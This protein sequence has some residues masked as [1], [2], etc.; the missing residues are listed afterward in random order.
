MNT[1]HPDT[2]SIISV[3]PIRNL[4]DIATIKKMLADNPRDLA[5]FVVGINTAF[6]AGDLLALTVGMVRN[7]NPG[8]TLPVRE[9]KT[10]K[11][12]RVTLN[13]AAHAAIRDLLATMPDATDDSPLFPSR[14]GSAALTVSTLNNLVKAWCHTINLTGNY[15]SHTLRKTFGYHH[16]VTFK[17][18]L[19]TLMTVF[20]HST[21]RQTLHYLCIQESAV[22]DAFLKEL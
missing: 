1:N 20:G 17:T 14:K 9:K 6:R 21:Q 3:E 5:L 12:R 16:H 13:K 7:L 10:G 8:D 2:D 22:Q 19:P 15:G 4:K 18:S 11:E